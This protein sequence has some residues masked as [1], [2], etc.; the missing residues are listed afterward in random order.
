MTTPQMSIGARMQQ[1]KENP[2]TANVGKKWT[3]EE[4][5][6]LMKLVMAKTSVDDMAKAHKRTP[7]SIQ[8][9]IL[10]LASKMVSD[11]KTVDEAAKEVNVHPEELTAYIAKVDRKSQR[12]QENVIKNNPEETQLTLLRK[13][14]EILATIC[15]HL[16][17][18]SLK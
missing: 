15:E 13:Q 16:R 4:N 8:Q 14:N 12:K 2:D 1:M 18:L 7:N 9:Q 11:T 10:K 6:E 3:N 5:D 17:I